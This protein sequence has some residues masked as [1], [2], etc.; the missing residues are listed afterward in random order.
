VDLSAMLALYPMRSAVLKESGATGKKIF[1][2]LNP[3]CESD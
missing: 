1:H 2:V 3:K